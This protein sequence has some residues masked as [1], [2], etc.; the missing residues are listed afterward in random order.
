MK[1]NARKPRVAIVGA[2]GLVGRAFARVLTERNINAE[3]ILFNTKGGAEVEIC[4]QTLVTLALT[5]DSARATKVDYALFSAGGDVSL[6]YSPIFA[7]NGAVVIDNSSAFRR[8]ADKILCVPECNAG[9]L[10]LIKD[11]A[12]IANPNCTTIAAVVALKPLDDAFTLTRVVYST[13]Q[14][15]SGAGDNPQFKYPIENNVITHIDGEEEKMVFETRKILGRENIGVSSTCIRVPVKNCHTIS[16]NAEF[17]K[18]VD[19]EV[20]KNLLRT[21][22]GVVFL[23]EGVLPMPINADNKDEVFVGRLRVDESRPNAINMVVVADNVRKGAATNAVQIL[24]CL[25]RS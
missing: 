15:I 13:Y 17:P 21:A 4:G 7:S 9:E 25:I 18:P 8:D 19:I 6:K 16:I 11:S 3:Y 2:T 24:E 10:A 23:E 5:E 14:A 20:A 12:I 1:K 22:P